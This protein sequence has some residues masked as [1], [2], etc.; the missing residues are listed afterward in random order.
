MPLALTFDPFATVI[1]CGVG[2][3]IFLI[4]EMDCQPYLM[5]IGN[6]YI[7]ANDG[8]LNQILFFKPYLNKCNG[9]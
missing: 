6:I 9:F 5:E 1:C 3:D 7:E 8:D 4:K 2:W